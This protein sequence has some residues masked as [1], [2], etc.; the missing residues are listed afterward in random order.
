MLPGN[1]V[2]D[3]DNERAF[4]IANRPTIIFTPPP[5]LGALAADLKQYEITLKRNSAIS[6]AL[7]VLKNAIISNLPDADRN[8]VSDSFFGLVAI[9]CQQLLDHLRERYGTFL[10][11]DFDAFCT[12]ITLKLE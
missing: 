11:S 6:E 1:D 5:A 2:N 9:S 7:R 8:E 4:I 12:E 10:A 3:P